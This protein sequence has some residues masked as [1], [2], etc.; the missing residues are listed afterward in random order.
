MSIERQISDIQ[1][2]KWL[3]FDYDRF[4]TVFDRNEAKI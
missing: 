3:L 1:K 2:E 4:M